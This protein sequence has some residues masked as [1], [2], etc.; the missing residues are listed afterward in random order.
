M[1]EIIKILKGMSRSDMN[2]AVSEISSFLCQENARRRTER[3]FVK[4]GVMWEWE[5]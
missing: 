4:S 2:N 5:K 1:D 3:A